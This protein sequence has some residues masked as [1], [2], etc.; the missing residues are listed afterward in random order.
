MYQKLAHT[1]FSAEQAPAIPS[2]AAKGSDTAQRFFRIP[3]VRPADQ[4]RDNEFK[5]K[6]W[7]YAHFDGKWIARQMELHP[8]KQPVLLIAGTFE[9]SI[10]IPI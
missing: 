4:H 9:E 3:F 7:W 5:K 10:V 6:G 8:D 1:L 2:R